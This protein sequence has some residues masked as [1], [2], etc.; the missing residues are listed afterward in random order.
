MVAISAASRAP[1][2]GTPPEAEL[3]QNPVRILGN[4]ERP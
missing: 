3:R 1:D 2:T 4:S